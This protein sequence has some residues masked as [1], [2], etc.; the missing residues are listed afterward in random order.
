[1]ND[2]EGSPVCRTGGNCRGCTIVK[3]GLQAALIKIIKLN[4]RAFY[5]ALTNRW[6]S[7]AEIARSY[8]TVAPTYD[9]EWSVQLAAVTISML[10]HLPRKVPDGDWLDLGCG[11]GLI[12]SKLPPDSVGVDTSPA[13]LHIAARR[14]PDSFFVKE[15]MLRYLRKQPDSSLS[16]I[17]SGW[18]IGYS[19]PGE[20]IAESSRV[21]RKDGIL[22][23][24]VNYHDSLAP[25][26][27]A[28]S[29]CMCLYPGEMNLALWPHFP[30]DREMLLRY[31]ARGAFD[32]VWQEDGEIPIKPPNDQALNLEWLL[33]TG[34][35]AGF[36]QVLPLHRNRKL[37]ADFDHLLGDNTPVTHHYF[38][39][40]FRKR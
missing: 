29:R 7:H 12:T 22:A 20:I 37:Q 38:A 4:L 9:A 39:G 6:L 15:D 27:K 31:L 40:V 26:F 32:Q 10:E 13:M 16:G 33:K 5:L 30:K 17:V 21:L 34:V 2:A 36:D 3:F 19:R 11:T 28:F 35:L 18:A 24:T 8:D 14:C 25:V 1:M 23:F